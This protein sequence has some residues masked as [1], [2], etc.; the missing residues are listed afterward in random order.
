MGQS[1][2][3]DG[4]ATLAT[5]VAHDRGLAADPLPLTADR[6]V[7]SLQVLAE[8]DETYETV[9]AWLASYVSQPHPDLGRSGPVCPF[10]APALAAGTVFFTAYRF[11]GEPSLERM[12]RALEEALR[13]FQLLAWQEE[14]VDLASLIVTFPDLAQDDW[15]L[16]DDGHRASKTRFVEAGCMLG[17]FHPAC[18]EPAAHNAAFPVNRAPVPLMVIRH[19]AS[20]DI[21]FL[22]EDPN[23]VEHFGA[24]LGRR[25]ISLKNPQYRRRFEQ[26]LRRFAP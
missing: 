23:W 20:H 4:W 14:K 11:D 19:I 3:D 16:I 24:W 10:A 2:R 15:H 8:G 12:T 9:S 18:E 13:C 1:D 17:Q 25:G 7:S 22:D 26:V 5:L 21:L 6:A